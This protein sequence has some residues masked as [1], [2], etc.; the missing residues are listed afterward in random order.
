MIG[1]VD[2]ASNE[3]EAQRREREDKTRDDAAKAVERA[4]PE[5]KEAGRQ[6]GQ[7]ASEAA[8]EARAFTEGVRQGWVSGGHHIV[9][10]NSASEND[11]MELPGISQTDARRIIR[12]R[13]YHET[14]ELVTKHIVSEDEYAKIRDITTVE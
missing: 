6:I 4:K 3:T 11:L 13:P 2:C 9:D 14:H 12:G 5:I 8:R 7:A 1:L 10:L